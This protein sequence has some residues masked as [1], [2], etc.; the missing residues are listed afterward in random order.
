MGQDY[1]SFATKQAIARQR[2]EREQWEAQQKAEREAQVREN[3]AA[4]QRYLDGLAKQKAEAARQQEAA[5]DA[6]LAPARE[7]AL[8]DWLLAHPGRDAD[9]F[10]GQ[11]WPLVRANLLEEQRAGVIEAT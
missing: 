2:A 1:Y 4:R 7:R 3:A 6:A 9:A 10:E 11:V 5:T 8:R